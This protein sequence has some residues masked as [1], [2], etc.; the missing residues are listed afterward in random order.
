MILQ[1]QDTVLVVPRLLVAQSPTERAVLP[2]VLEEGEE[3][4]MALKMH[5][6]Y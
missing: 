1:G 4:D 5:M 2:L 3:R 6:A